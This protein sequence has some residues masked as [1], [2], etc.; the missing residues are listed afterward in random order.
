MNTRSGTAFTLVELLVVITIIAILIALLLPAVQA[1]R[2][3]AR[4]VQCKNNLKQIG[5]AY[6]SCEQDLGRFPT[7]GWGYKW[8]GD[9]NLGTDSNQVGGWIFNTLPYFEQRSLHDLALGLQGSAKSA[10]LAR[11]NS[12]PIA[13]LYCPSRRR[14]LA[15]PLSAAP[16]WNADVVRNC[17]KTDYAANAGDGPWCIDNGYPDGSSLLSKTTETGVI[18]QCSMVRVRDV[19]DGL[20]NTY[21]LGEKYVNLDFYPTGQDNGDDQSAYVGYDIDV[22]RWTK[23][24]TSRSPPIVFPPLPDMPGVLQYHNFGSAHAGACHFI[25]CDGAV[26]SISYAIDAEVHRRFGNRSDGKPVDGR[27][28]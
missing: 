15:Y 1:A 6:L 26:R 25:F 16:P 28:F 20:S 2:E 8:I 10:A 21:L 4:Q 24:D 27:N 3:A 19:T 9:P 12:T 17:A 7:G 23:N 5:L 14:T 22:C 18:Y 13:G 11:M